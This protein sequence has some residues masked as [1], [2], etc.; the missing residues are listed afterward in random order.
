ML[1]ARTNAL[2]RVR[3]PRVA[4]RDGPAHFETSALRSPRKIGPNWFI[5]ALVNS[6]FG[7]SGI[8]L[9]LGTSVCCFE[10]KKSRNDWRISAEVSCEVVRGR[11][12]VIRGRRKV[13]L[14]APQTFLH[15]PPNHGRPTFRDGTKILRR[16]PRFGRD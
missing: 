15:G 14:G 9:E 8:R 7:L 10:R 11:W 1:A 12:S 13:R 4:A 6:R 5:P 16:I 3:G 2:L